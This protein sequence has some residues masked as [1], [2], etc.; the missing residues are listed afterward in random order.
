M[1]ERT[2]RSVSKQLI[3]LSSSIYPKQ[4][5]NIHGFDKFSNQKKEEEKPKVDL[6]KIKNIEEFK[7]KVQRYIG[8]DDEI[9]TL[10]SAL[11]ERKREK[12]RFEGEILE[13]MKEN[14]IE[15]IKNKQDNSVI[16]LVQKKRTETL[17]KEYLTETLM[18]LLKNKTTAQNI[19]EYVYSK[20]GVIEKSIIK[21]MRE[22]GKR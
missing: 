11:R 2:V 3:P 10:T 22:K 17:S 12:Q 8:L 5:P 4:S 21:R 16:G 18:E 7:E 15:T 20:R 13:F 14:E 19:S 1:D 9:M 6:R